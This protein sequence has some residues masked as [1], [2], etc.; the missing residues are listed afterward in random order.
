MAVEGS[1]LD[2]WAYLAR[3]G[4]QGRAPTHQ[5]F[6]DG[7]AVCA[8]RTVT[9]LTQDDQEEFLHPD[10]TPF[11]CPAPECPLDTP[12][13][14][15]H[16]FETHY[17]SAHAH[18]CQACPGLTLPSAH[19]LA[20]HV[21]EA[22]DAYFA[23]MSER[24]ASFECFLEQCPRKFWQPQQ[25]K[26]H[27]W[28]D[29]QFLGQ[30]KYL[31]GWWDAG[32]D[33]SKLPPPPR[34]PSLGGV[35]MD[36][37]TTR[38]SCQP[39][40]VK[41]TASPSSIPQPV[42]PAGSP[43]LF[44]PNPSKL[45]RP[46][47]LSP[48][49]RSARPSRPLS[50]ADSPTS[51]RGRDPVTTPTELD[52]SRFG[53]RRNSLEPSHVSDSNGGIQRRFSLTPSAIKKPFN[54]HSVALDHQTLSSDIIMDNSPTRTT[55]L[56]LARM[57]ERGGSSSSRK[58]SGVSAN[59]VD[60]SSAGSST[61]NSPYSSHPNSNLSSQSGLGSSS[62]NSPNKRSR[63]P[64]FHRSPSVKVPAS[65]SFGANVER[66]FETPWHRDASASSKQS[67]RNSLHLERS[68]FVAEM[69]G[70]LDC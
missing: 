8:M 14:Q 49:K 25:R 44:R 43:V 59:S 2:P 62:N 9:Y 35:R 21:A 33:S 27:C 26:E 70:A 54:R 34:S 60:L 6:L 23:V 52:R 12:F 1:D 41:S 40:P 38:G 5:F 63:I 46:M 20:L 50:V 36:C 51:S 19:L 17:A 58:S 7:D 24:R 16:A 39:A 11:H 67:N 10:L 66:G 64:V 56:S 28:S 42:A 68:N 29:H 65:I 69:R 22:H 32:S 18:N 55:P 3:L 13:R 53:F 15:L 57:G 48:V 30:F 37:S 31:D 47:S 45:R 61:V 4:V